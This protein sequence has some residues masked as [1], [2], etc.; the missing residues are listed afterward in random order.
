MAPGR[1]D[2]MH[3]NLLVAHDF[4]I[5]V[6]GAVLAV[7]ASVRSADRVGTI[8]GRI[9]PPYASAGCPARPP[10]LKVCYLRTFVVPWTLAELSAFGQHVAL[11]EK[12][13]HQSLGLSVPDTG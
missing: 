6:P 12:F 9:A 2:L 1:V 11:V 3:D 13:V 4:S 7:Q 10:R 5:M 8:S